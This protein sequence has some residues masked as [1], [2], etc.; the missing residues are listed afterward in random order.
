MSACCYIKRI[1]T[2]CPDG[3]P[4]DPSGGSITPDVPVTYPNGG[5][6]GGVV[7]PP[8][9]TVTL[10]PSNM[11]S[12]LWFQCA[13][14]GCHNGV[15][16]VR[17][18]NN[19][20]TLL[21]SGCPR[22]SGQN[23]VWV[24][25]NASL[26]NRGSYVHVDYVHSSQTLRGGL[27]SPCAGGHACNGAKFNVGL[28][29][30]IIGTANMNNAGVT[31]SNDGGAGYDRYNKFN[32]PD[33][34][35]DAY[36]ASI[37]PV[38]PGSP[39]EPGNVDVIFVSTTT[40]AI[41]WNDLSQGESGYEIE[42]K[43][44]GNWTLL[45]QKPANTSQ[46]IYTGTFGYST[47]Y[48]FRIRTLGTPNSNW[49]E[50]SVTT[51][52]PP[53]PGST[54]AVYISQTRIAL[55]WDDIYTGETGFEIQRKPNNGTFATIAT[56]GS[57]VNTYNDDGG[58]WGYGATFVYRVRAVGASPTFP[59]AYT[60]EGTVTTGSA[61]TPATGVAVTYI[62]QTKLVVVWNDTSTSETGYEVERKIGN[63]NWELVATL[64]SNKTIYK[65][66]T[67]PSALAS[68]GYNTQY[69]YRV[70]STAVGITSPWSAEGTITTPPPPDLSLRGICFAEWD[71][72]TGWI[73]AIAGA[74]ASVNYT[75]VGYKFAT[76]QPN[77]T[78]R[79]ALINYASLGIANTS[80]GG[81][82]QFKSQ[83]GA[84]LATFAL[85]LSSNGSSL[86]PFPFDGSS[87]DGNPVSFSN[88]TGVAVDVVAA[89]GIPGFPGIYFDDSLAYQI[90]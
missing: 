65:D 43:V 40:L 11:N 10:P 89:G 88:T 50:R 56:V 52:A 19:A 15:G 85:N 18:Y 4:V 31:A 21:Y 47:T 32:I 29:D 42:E 70:R 16:F 73:E 9:G 68:F 33:S 67:P 83:G 78:I 66:T 44:G 38:T 6:I 34:I 55:A 28:G 72:C 69:S 2:Q 24:S 60:S 46:H 77:Q 53:V 37:N 5:T 14:N 17:L 82:I 74:T 49:V 8:G 13:Y 20:G 35:V 22:T 80:K 51:P 30:N 45:V 54:R 86:S 23:K 12:G 79:F 61:P 36:T 63:G 87:I 27:V 25:F 84:V 59:T 39:S 26:L 58:S 1:E 64:A 7:I 75:P 48:D 76:L 62:S 90:I 81:Q 41:N 71:V 57:N 3:T